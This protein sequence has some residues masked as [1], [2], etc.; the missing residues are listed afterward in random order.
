M[1]LKRWIGAASAVAQVTK[2]TFSSYASTET[3]T[4]T[5]NGKD[6]SFTSVTGTNSEI[7]AGLVS[8]WEA[9][10][11]PEA[12]EIVASVDTGV[13]LT[14]R[15]AG[16][17]FVVSASATT[18]TAT[19][20]GVTAATG[21]NHFA[22][23]DNWEG[24]SA[25][26]AADDLLFADSSIDLLYGLAVGIALGTITIDRSFT[27][28]IGLPRINSNGYQE[29][30]QRY[31]ELDADA[32][33]VIGAG[34][35]IGSSRLLIDGGAN[36][37]TA[38]V[39]A[40]SQGENNDRAVQFTNLD[41]ASTLSVFGASVE[42]SGAGGLAALD[43]IARQ[44]SSTAPD[45]AIKGGA[46]AGVVRASGQNAKVYLE[47][48]ATSIDAT[49]GCQVTVAS[50]ATC[51]TVSVS[52]TATV[53]WD[54]SGAISTD[55]FVYGGGIASFARRAVSRTVADAHVHTG[56]TIDDPF[57][58]VTWTAGVTLVGLLAEVKLNLG[59]NITLT[60]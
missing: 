4:I 56:G 26:S 34:S 25:P 24:G 49:A 30:R 53:F 52:N 17:P 27:G 13:V 43:V 41:D 50:A 2:V 48:N 1:A 29:Y 37:V 58:S 40:A 9:S 55:L 14:S 28:R 31:L 51:P 45:V 47:G 11:V 60:I 44:D 7:W 42:V 23:D 33:V 57:Q 19:V 3:Y 22:N 36:V 35:G 12:V 39:Y 10:A 38:E 54:S 8:A 32:T 59:R 46:V 5:V 16:V 18:G 15:V 6:I 20:T 21:P